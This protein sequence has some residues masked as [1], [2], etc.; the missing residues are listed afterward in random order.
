[1]DYMLFRIAPSRELK[2]LK[3]GP[4]MEPMFFRDSSFMELVLCKSY[5]HKIQ[6]KL[7]LIKKSHFCWNLILISIQKNEPSKHEV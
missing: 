1:M 5:H 2:F 6:F 4:F 3:Y 7:E